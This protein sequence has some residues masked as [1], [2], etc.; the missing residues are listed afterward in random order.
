MPLPRRPGPYLLAFLLLILAALAAWLF[1]ALDAPELAAAAKAR[2]DAVAKRTNVTEPLPPPPA[3]APPA[4]VIDPVH[5][6]KA[7]AL[8]SPEITPQQDLEI[9]A[10]FIGIY[11]KALGGNPIGGNEDITAALTGS[12]G[13]KGRV[14]PPAHKA[15]R[16]GQLIDRW[17]TPYWFHPNSS[18]QMEIR[19]AG[20]DKQLF[21]PDDV[22]HN[23][24][25]AGLGAT[26]P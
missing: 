22:V 3:G 18:S 4:V 24:S 20:P 21:T 13:H 9:I 2:G 7:A 15:V 11:G 10:E 6:E 26:P 16:D 19:S 14:F 23:P 8:H 25:P 5:Q 12:E 17:G 1:K